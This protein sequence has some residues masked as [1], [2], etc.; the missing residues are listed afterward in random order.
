MPYR[1]TN[2]NGETRTYYK[3]VDVKKKP[4]GRPFL[5]K[6]ILGFKH[7]YEND[8]ITCECGKIMKFRSKYTHGKSKRHQEYINNLKTNIIK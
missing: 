3:K 7:R 4:P 8:N 1:Y 2:K 6:G 5:K